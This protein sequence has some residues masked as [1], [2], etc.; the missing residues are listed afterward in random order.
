MTPIQ[1]FEDIDQV[2]FRTEIQP[3][4]Q[5]AVLRGL[6]ADWPLVHAGRNG[7]DALFTAL[8]PRAPAREADVLELPARFEGR[9]LHDADC[10]GFN[11]ERRRLSLKDLF[12]RLKSEAGAQ[13]PV[14]LFAG[15][16]PLRDDLQSLA[17]EHAMSLLDGVEER[18]TSL[19][20]GNRTRTA[21]HWDLPSNLAT[22]IAGRRRFILY[23]PE[24]IRDLYIGPMDRTIAGQPV[25]LVDP[26]QPDL[27]RFPDYARAQDKALTATLEPGDTLYMPSLWVHF[28]QSLDPVSMMLNIWWREG[29]PHTV[30]PFLTLLHGLLTLRDLPE[31]ERQAWKH[32]FDHFI[33]DAANEAQPYLSDEAKGVFGPSTEAVRSRIR[34]HLLRTLQR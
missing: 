8:G 12:A 30:T 34:Q 6:C 10:T 33:F 13:Q 28:V 31:H 26:L 19:W 3:R 22:V 9:F 24:C 25:S 17:D 15:A 21:P 16:V 29:P 11:F 23:P 18:L 32:V 4:N 14:S 27:E 20:I 2:R 5:P 7:A 1:I